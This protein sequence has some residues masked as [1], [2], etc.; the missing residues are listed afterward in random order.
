METEKRE[1]ECM[2]GDS[3]ERERER[4]N[5]DSEERESA[6]MKTEE[7]GGC[8]ERESEKRQGVYGW[9]W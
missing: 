2:N 8:I 4:M 7:R 3:E 1:R 6:W 5:G 9:R